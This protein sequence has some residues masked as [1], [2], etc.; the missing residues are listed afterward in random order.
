MPKGDRSDDRD[1]G[2]A[3]RAGGDEGE[4]QSAWTGPDF[5]AMLSEVEDAVFLFDV[6]RVDGEL[7][8]RFRW[9]NPVHESR[10]GMTVEEYGGQT[11]RDFFDDSTATAVA[12]NYRRCVE[13]RETIEYEEVLEHPSGRVEWHT[14]LT[15]VVEEGRVAKI[16]GVARDVTERK[17]RER[18]LERLESLL[19]EVEEMADIGAYEVDLETDEMWWTVGLRRLLGV[20]D[21]FEPT[22]ESS[23][24]FYH[25]GDRDRV[26]REY[27]R[28]RDRGEPAQFEARVVTADGTERLVESYASVVE[29]GDS[30]RLRGYVQDVTD[31]KAE[32]RKLARSR[33]LLSKTEQLAAVGGWELDCGTEELRWTD[34]IREIFGVGADYEP[35]LGAA[36]EF[37]HPE[38]RARIESL[39][40]RCRT[41]GEPYDEVLRITTGEGRRRRVRSL[42]EP[43]TEDG[44]VV[45][46]RG[47]VLDVT[48]R[49]E[50]EERLRRYKRA[51]DGATDLISAFDLEDR[52]I[53]ANPQYCRYHGIDT[54][55]VTDRSLRDV[56]TEDEYVEIA[57]HRDRALQ[58]ESA[59]YQMVR[60]HPTRGQRILDVQ[61]Y[62]IRDEGEVTGVVAIL[63]DV[64]DREERAKHLQV[65]NRVLRHD[66]RN[67]LTVI[68]GWADELVAGQEPAVAETAR[69]ISQSAEELLSSS[70]KAQPITDILIDETQMA[71]VDVSALV[72]RVAESCASSQPDAEVTVEAPEAVTARCSSR[73]S[74]A[75]RELVQNAIDHNDGESSTVEIRVERAGNAVRVSVLDDGPGMSG[76]DR[77]VLESGDPPENL[78]HG[79]GLG[80]WMVY[81]IVRRS[82][83]DLSVT[84]RGAGGSKVTIGLPASHPDQ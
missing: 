53:F 23:L 5:E 82:N 50:R 32:A 63:R 4:K 59:R 65:V 25:P 11:P 84:D 71:S 56:F 48:E 31:R 14:K 45:A 43:V 33:G 75:V 44:E 22:P 18:R 76:M 35:T 40:D 21:A 19:S 69:A 24:E 79:S 17:R 66:I 36:I 62:T 37:Y 55:A 80:L 6:G 10:T 83:G 64:T 67:K 20:D 3:S 1:V 28:T 15:P 73:L 16:I 57:R 47:A 26:A 38:D 52:F 41:R 13:T 2:R 58:G 51:I 30:R 9:N 46:L 68:Q 70:V 77:A 27:A 54:D 78:T 61:Y 29:F 60:T 12:G 81:W 49:K 34:G 42:G 7:E 8:F 74:E 72:T 39:V